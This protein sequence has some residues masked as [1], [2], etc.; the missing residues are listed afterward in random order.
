MSASCQICISPYNRSNRRPIE[1][2]S[3]HHASCSACA[4]TYILSTPQDPHCMH[5][6]HPW[7]HEFLH[8]HLTKTFLNTRLRDHREQVLFDREKAMLPATQIL[9]QERK[10]RAVYEEQL[11]ALKQQKQALQLQ[12]ADLNDQMSNVRHTI[13]NGSNAVV[14]DK[15]HRFTY[16]CPAPDCKGYIDNATHECGTCQ[17]HMCPTCHELMSVTDAHECNHDTVKTIQKLQ[18]DTKPCPNCHSLIHKTIGCAQ[19][20]CTKCHH[21]FNWSTGNTE[22][23]RIHNPE[24]QDLQRRLYQFAPTSR[25]PA[26]FPCG[27]LV[28]WHVIARRLRKYKKAIPSRKQQE[29]IYVK[30]KQLEEIHRITFHV[31][32]HVLPR[33][34]PDNNTFA[35]NASIRMAYLENQID[36]ATLKRR[37]LLSE[38]KHER[39]TAIHAL[40]HSLT[41]A[42]QDIFHRLNADSQTL[43][44]RSTTLSELLDTYQ[45]EFD[46]LH[47]LYKDNAN[48]VSEQF[49][50]SVPHI[51]FDFGLI[52]V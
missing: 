8:Q 30:I 39:K 40:L 44:N 14:T 21:A 7:N 16:A 10:Q 48:Y 43:P 31:E 17:S 1:C 4:E 41:L 51:D 12:I 38:R 18:K 9:I 13:R 19:M 37:L 36:D 6:R 32:I 15:N 46:A 29:A 2:V 27:G 35:R 5:C 23:G 11:E 47:A 50:C 33:Y 25:D 24:W 42:A 28:E 20:F 26:D 45:N 22:R 52:F 3:C 34:R 49:G